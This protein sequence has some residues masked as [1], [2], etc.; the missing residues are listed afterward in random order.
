MSKSRIQARLHC[1]N[2]PR[3]TCDVSDAAVLMGEDDRHEQQSTRDGRH[4][5]E[6]GGDHA[7]IA[8]LE[9]V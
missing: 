5:E 4:D 8:N 6:I 1:V 9:V 2:S 3:T 7:M